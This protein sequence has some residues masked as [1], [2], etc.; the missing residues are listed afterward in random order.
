[1]GSCNHDRAGSEV[2]Q[3]VT[4]IEGSGFLELCL[5]FIVI[6]S[7]SGSLRRPLRL[8]IADGHLGGDSGLV[9]TI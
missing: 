6:R 8:P 2:N 1:M 3:L 5:I 4:T 9:L 7:I